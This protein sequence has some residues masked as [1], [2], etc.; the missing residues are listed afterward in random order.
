MVVPRP[1]GLAINDDEGSTNTLR[2]LRPRDRGQRGEK[3]GGKAPGGSGQ[4]QRGITPGETG[5]GAR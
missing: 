1:P 4:L 5:S 2:G 3:G